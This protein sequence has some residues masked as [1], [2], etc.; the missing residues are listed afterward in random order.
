MVATTPTSLKDIIARRR[1]QPR[2][3]LLADT[4]KWLAG[5]P[6]DV[7]PRSLPIEFVRI[8]N[9]MA[10]AWS[11]PRTCLEYFDDLLIDRRGDRHGFPGAVAFELAALKNYYENSVHPTTQTVWDEITA[12]R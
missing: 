6:A 1:P 7:R 12:R 8:A 2:E 10:R 4:V 5:L 11:T 9:A 3:A